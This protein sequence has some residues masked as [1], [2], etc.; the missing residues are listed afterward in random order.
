MV[1]EG[2]S[3]VLLFTPPLKDHTIKRSILRYRQKNFILKYSSIT[4]YTEN[5]GS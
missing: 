1:I 3:G 4:S 5:R 2:V